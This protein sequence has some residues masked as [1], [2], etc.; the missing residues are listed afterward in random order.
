MTLV[1]PT[2]EEIRARALERYMQDM[3]REGLED[4]PTPEDY[5][6]KEANYWLRAQQ[7]LMTSPEAKAKDETLNFLERSASELEEVVVKSEELKELLEASR[8]LESVEA[9]MKDLRETRKKEQEQAKQRIADLETKLEEARAE[10]KKRATL[11]IRILKDFTEGILKYQQGSIMKTPDIQWALK[12]VDEGYAERVEVGVP[13][14]PTRPPA[15][16]VF[17]PK[18]RELTKEEIQRLQDLWS[19]TFF[20]ELGRVPA[21]AMATFRVEVEK[22]KYESYIE[23]QERLLG[24]ARDII[25]EF[26]ARKVV[27]RVEVP[28]RVEVPVPEEY[29]AI[30]RV[31]PTEPPKEPLEPKEMRFPRGP[32]SREQEVLWDAFRYRLQE[33]GYNPF[34]YEDLFQDYIAGTQFHSWEDLLKKFE[35]FVESIKK[36]PGLPPLWQWKGVPIPVGLEGVLRKTPAERLQDVIV[37]FTSVV[38]R[39]ARGRGK[40]ATLEDLKRELD[41]RGLIP[42]DMIIT[43]GS[44]LYDEIKNALMAAYKREDVWLT[45]ISLEELDKFLET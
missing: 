36:G 44:P 1:T 37:H 13:V 2:R 26:V 8:D 3:F 9:K 14:E 45:K 12:K 7:E 4:I 24:V 6:L 25:G 31:P 41:E 21:N 32:S 11:K 29:M 19:D 40:E 15:P 28:R 20:R 10:A 42:P 39:N 43:P 5:E 17:L 35:F 33:Q 34:E 23:A 27:E 16:P 18:R 30:A 22:V 38:I